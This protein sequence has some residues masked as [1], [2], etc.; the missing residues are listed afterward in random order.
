MGAL[1]KLR[2]W[3][4]RAGSVFDETIGDT[5]LP[6]PWRRLDFYMVGY[7]PNRTGAPYALVRLTDDGTFHVEYQNAPHPDPADPTPNLRAA[8]SLVESSWTDHR[9]TLQLIDAAIEEANRAV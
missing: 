7:Y 6:A 5:L 4:T 1:A 2:R 3:V 8:M 9:R